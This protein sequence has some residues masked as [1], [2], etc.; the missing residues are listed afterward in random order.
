M[1][2]GGLDGDD[3]IVR[4]GLWVCEIGGWGALEKFGGVP[5]PC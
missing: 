1:V 3:G 2:R 4:L 5:L